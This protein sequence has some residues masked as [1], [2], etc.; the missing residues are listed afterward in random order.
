MLAQGDLA[1]IDPADGVD[2][3][4]ISALPDDYTPTPTSLVG[5][6]AAR[7]ISVARLGALKARDLR[8]TTGAWL[9]HPVEEAGFGRLV[10]FEPGWIGDP[11]Q[12]VGQLFRALFPFLDE[13]EDQVI[14]MPLISSGDAGWPAEAMMP[15]LLD[16]AVEWLRLGLPVR[17]LYIVARNAPQIERMREAFE[18]KRREE[19]PEVFERRSAASSAEA[20]PSPMSA[21]LPKASRT[22]FS[23][24]ALIGLAA[25]VM[26]ASLAVVFLS[27]GSV[28]WALVPLLLAT[29]FLAA[30]LLSSSGGGAPAP[31]PAEAPRVPEDWDAPLDGPPAKQVFLSFSSRDAEAADRIA[32]AFREVAPE[33]EVFDFRRDIEIG[34]SYQRRIDAALKECEHALCLLSPDYMSSGECEEELMVARLRNKRMG[35]EFLWPVYWRGL[36]GDL[37]DWIMILNLADC[38][39]EDAGELDATA[40]RLAARLVPAQPGPVAGPPPRG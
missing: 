38:R 13:A 40:R 12:V 4:V 26:G 29:I 17:T 14:A 36:P 16:A 37:E 25:T 22:P 23:I 18:T 20:M 31:A 15:P 3:L 11:P 30:W 35:F 5:Q 27:G 7:G 8:E 32:Q 21:P 1:R 39:E 10:C 24:A 33:V 2:L 9:S 19:A 6:L 34:V 28:I